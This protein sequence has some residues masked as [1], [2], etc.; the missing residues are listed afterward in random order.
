MG[1]ATLVTVKRGN[2]TTLTSNQYI[3]RAFGGTLV[4]STTTTVSNVK[5][6]HVP[7]RFDNVSP[8][9][10]AQLGGASPYNTYRIES[11]VGVPD[12]ETSDQLM[13][14]VNID[15]KTGANVLYRVMGNPEQYDGSYLE[16]IVEKI[17]GKV[18]A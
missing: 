3:P 4:L 18:P 17:V 8:I 11:M 13:D 12:I 15:P 2:P 10:A 16:C 1:F 7:L 14:E 6:Q 5:A 9:V